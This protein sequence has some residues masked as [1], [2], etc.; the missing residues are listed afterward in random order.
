MS[1]KIITPLLI[2]LISLVVIFAGA[3]FYFALSLNKLSSSVIVVEP[4]K[5]TDDTLAETAETSNESENADTTTTNTTPDG[6]VGV[7]D[8]NKTIDGWTL[9]SGD[10]NDACTRPTYNG[11][12]ELQGWYVY[13]YNYVEKDWLFQVTPDDVDNIPIATILGDTFDNWA[14][15]P[16]YNLDNVTPE[17]EAELKAATE[18]NP[19]TITVKGFSVYC[20]GAPVLNLNSY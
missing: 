6:T 11:E 8:A 5:E 2:V 13:D 20:E 16:H 12:T 3:T 15:K 18:K 17:L 1:Q 9:V 14:E 7:A 4:P 10:P 19:K